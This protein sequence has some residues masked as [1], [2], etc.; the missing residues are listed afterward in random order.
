[1]TEAER[2]ERRPLH[3]SSRTATYPR[4]L[5]NRNAVP[6]VN[7]VLLA[8]NRRDVTCKVCLGI[9]AREKKYATNKD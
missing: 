8:N 2:L 4:T 7:Q 3:A 9:L 5:C 1:M 6:F